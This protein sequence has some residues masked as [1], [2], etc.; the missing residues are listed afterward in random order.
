MQFGKGFHTGKAS[1]HPH[2]LELDPLPPPSP[3][4]T[5]T[6]LLYPC[7]AIQN[8]VGNKHT[9]AFATKLLGLGFHLTRT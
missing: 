6:P 2:G 3:Q 7:A 9:R 5:R 1:E 4:R 8:H